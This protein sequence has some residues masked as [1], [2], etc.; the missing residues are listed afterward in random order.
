MSIELLTNEHMVSL[1]NA[2]K[3]TNKHIKIISPFIGLNTSKLISEFMKNNIQCECTVITRFYTQDFIDRVSNLEGLKL[4]KQSNAKLYALKNLHSKLYLIDDNYGIIGSANFT[5]GGFKSNHELS[6]AIK[7][8]TCLLNN[9]NEYFDELKDDI[10]HAGDWEITSEIIEKEIELTDRMFKNS[11][12]K[13]VKFT[14]SKI[15]GADIKKINNDK[16]IKEIDIVE[17]F[18]KEDLAKSGEIAWIK[19]EGKSDNRTSNKFKYLP[20]KI[21]S[22]N[23][24]IT[25]FPKNPRGIENGVT[26]FLSKLSYDENGKSV[27]MIVGRA[28]SYGFNSSNIADDFDKKQAKWLEDYPYYVE[29][30]DIEIIDTEIVNGISLNTLIMQLGNDVFPNTVGKCLENE[31]IRKRTRRRSHLR[32][33]PM[34][35]KYLDDKL[36]CLL[37]KY[38][39]RKV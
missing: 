28:K 4:L 8:E 18:L 2:L 16:T 35:K 6:L 1:T 29:L 22:K 30:Y 10:R 5:M 37:N 15:W 26:I 13:S 31:D 12:D 19:F 32:L 17:E 27:P 34:S 33:T 23:M 7:D 38:G 36:E 20:H 21:I 14:N 24:Y 11:N 9:L 3:N 39:K 25:C